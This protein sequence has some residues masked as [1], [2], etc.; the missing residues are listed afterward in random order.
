MCVL[1]VY[2][3]RVILRGDLTVDKC[4]NWIR[5][6]LFGSGGVGDIWLKMVMYSG[7]FCRICGVLSVM[8]SRLI[9]RG[10]LTVDKCLNWIRKELFEESEFL[11]IFG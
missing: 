1:S 4:L 10:D 7:G 3:I 5:K 2:G 11:V 8:G 6:E 9:L